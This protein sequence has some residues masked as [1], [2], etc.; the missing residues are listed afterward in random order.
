MFCKV[1][2]TLLEARPLCE[3]SGLPVRY[4]TS[5]WEAL[6]PYERI[7]LTMRGPASLWEALPPCE[8]PCLPVRGLASLWGFGFLRETRPPCK[9]PTFLW[10]A[11]ERPGL[12]LRG[13]ASL[14]KAWPSFMRHTLPVRGP[15]SIREAR[16][17]FERP[18]LSVRHLVSLWEDRPPCKRPRKYEYK[19][20]DAILSRKPITAIFCHKIVLTHIS[21]AGKLWLPGSGWITWD[22]SFL[23][24]SLQF[25]PPQ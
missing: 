22:C 7:D 24:W 6:P 25:F 12:P 10:E 19:S 16:V 23:V 18:G 3:R 5:L 13:P 8:R 21:E 15:F 11:C 14:W 4:P 9:S 2:I 17:L 1:W 20:W